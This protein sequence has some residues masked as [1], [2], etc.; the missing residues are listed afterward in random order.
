MPISQV[1]AFIRVPQFKKSLKVLFV[2]SEAAPFAKVGGLGEVMF[3]LPRALRN[4]GHDARVM[5]PRYASVS[6]DKYNLKIVYPDL[7]VPSGGEAPPL[8]CNVLGYSGPDTAPTF[9]LE[10]MEYYEKRAN[11]YGYSDDPVRWVLFSRGVLEFLRQS[12]WVPD[13]IVANDWQTGFVPNL[14]HTDYKHDP[15]L[16]YIA[17]TFVIHNLYHQGMFDHRFVPE[18]EYDAGQEPIGDIFGKRLPWLNGMRRGIMHAD[19]VAT[20]SPTYSKEILTKD[21]GEGLENLLAER[22]PHLYGILNGINYEKLDPASD[23]YIAAKYDV[24]SVAARQKNKLALQEQ[25]GLEKN[26]QAFVMGIVSRM[27]TQ[28]GFDLI[29][30]M[31]HPLF[32]EIDCQLVVVGTGD[33]KYRLFFKDL[34]SAFPGRVGGHFEYDAAL[35]R[36]IFAGSDIVLI[37]SMFEPC[38]LTQMEAMRYGAIP[39][40]RKTGGLADTIT[41]FTGEASNGDGFLFEKPDPWSLFAT[42]IKARE[43][44]RYPR[45][46]NELVKRAMRKNFSWLASAES[47]IKIFQKAIETHKEPEK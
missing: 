20:V 15:V 44:Y 14:L 11:V 43:T 23:P 46:W 32:R 28:K 18:M 19:V 29:M 12:E 47:Y 6:P 17:T 8:V 13:I 34:I 41:D 7:E 22:R 38:G 35:P 1:A 30:P 36:L 10:N 37:P 21:Y 27:D 16:K 5:M 45:I 31:A 3:S 39:V 4:L 9:F 2:A 24:N 42:I 25:F 40:A 33:N 26:P